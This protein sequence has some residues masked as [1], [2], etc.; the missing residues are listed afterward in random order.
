M[1]NGTKSQSHAFLIALIVGGFAAGLMRAQTGSG[2]E[3]PNTLRC[4]YMEDPLGVDTAERS[5]LAYDL[6][7]QTTYPSWGYMVS[8]GATTLWELWEEKAGP[9]MNSH[10][11]IMFGS[12][13]AWFYQALAGINQQEG[14]SGYRHL[15][16]QP[17]AAHGLQWAGGTVRTIRGTVGSSWAREAGG[18]T[19]K[20]TVPVG[21]DAR[22]MVPRPQ[23]MT[24]VVVE[25]N[26]RAVWED[27][28][29]VPGDPGITGAAAEEDVIAFELGSGEYTFR[30]RGE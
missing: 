8:R 22:V 19:M 20:V 30:V 2:P 21:S 15:R 24:G 28:K 10:D 27:G 9:S 17:R 5:D 7:A 25:E 14:A 11:H 12:V 18:V 26:G 3:A 13:G 4:E 16:V 1:L 23:E 6:A 29:Y